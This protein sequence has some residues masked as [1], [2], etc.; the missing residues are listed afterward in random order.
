MDRKKVIWKWED[1]DAQKSFVEWVGFPDER[2]TAAELEK[3]EAL[4]SLKPPITALDVGCGTGRHALAMARKGYNVVGIDV[5]KS[6]LETARNA[7]RENDLEVEFRLERASDLEENEVYDFALAYDHTLGFMSDEELERHFSGI[8][9]ALKPGG[10]LLLS[11]A[12]PQSV[13]GQKDYKTRSWEEKDGR[14]I[15]VEKIFE[16]DYREENCIVIDPETSEVTE[17]NERQKA[18]S[19]EEVKSLLNSSE[20]DEVRCYKDLMGN[21]STAD[22]FN[23]FLCKKA[24]G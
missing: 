1:A 8:H 16:H 6:Y 4:V 18:F 23:V 13:P 3:I 19:L 12:G 17:F 9:A 20:F 14:F 11:L 10:S 2:A 22:S 5:A 15:L 7:A 24:R 21:P